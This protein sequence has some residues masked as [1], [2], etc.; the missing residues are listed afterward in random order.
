MLAP[1]QIQPLP[2]AGN[3]P[4]HQVVQQQAALQFAQPN[5]ARYLEMARPDILG[6]RVHNYFIN[7]VAPLIRP[8]IRIE[9]FNP[10]QREI[11]QRYINERVNEVPILPILQRFN[12]RPIRPLPIA[13]ILPVR[14][15]EVI[16]ALGGVMNI[17][18]D[19]LLTAFAIYTMAVP[20]I[21][22]VS[23]G[24]GTAIAYK[25]SAL[26]RRVAH[27]VFDLVNSSDKQI[28]LHALIMLGVVVLKPA[29]LLA[30]SYVAGFR[31]SQYVLKDN[32]SPFA[33]ALRG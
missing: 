30:G 18:T 11:F 1:A 8:N 14:G 23:L 19:Y 15:L 17:Y 6:Q 32:V 28:V 13:D 12:L 16:Y 20:A 3:R 27:A 2:D 24:A 9:N 31:L 26:V 7:N 5:I 29:T 22:A 10:R 25:K 33:V 4:A 21:I